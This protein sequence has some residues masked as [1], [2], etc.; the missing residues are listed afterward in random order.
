MDFDRSPLEPAMNTLMPNDL[1][2]V[3]DDVPAGADFW[4]WENTIDAANFARCSISNRMS[5]AA[6]LRW[7]PAV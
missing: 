6:I 2:P 1:G 5:L 4:V 7:I 3:D